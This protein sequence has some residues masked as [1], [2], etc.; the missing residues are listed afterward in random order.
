MGFNWSDYCSFRAPD[1]RLIR[2]KVC[3]CVYFGCGGCPL[4]SLRKGDKK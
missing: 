4:C 3:G 2:C 1:F